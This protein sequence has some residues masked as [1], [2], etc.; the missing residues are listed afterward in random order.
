MRFRVS[1]FGIRDSG[2]GSP[3]E[4]PAVKK[5][6][7]STDVTGVC[8]NGRGSARGRGVV[9]GGEGGKREGGEGG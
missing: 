1:G 8:V 5:S 9:G 6:L 2:F 7:S 3:H 4:S